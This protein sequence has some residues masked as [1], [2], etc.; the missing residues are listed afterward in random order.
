V[1]TCNAVTLP[2]N[3]GFGF[4]PLG[5]PVKI[6]IYVDPNSQIVVTATLRTRPFSSS[7]PSQIEV[8]GTPCSVILNG[9]QIS[10]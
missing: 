9:R 1:A 5:Q 7:P 4:V 6:K 2:E 8:A 10:D 3:A